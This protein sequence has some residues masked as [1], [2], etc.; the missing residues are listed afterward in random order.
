MSKKINLCFFRNSFRVHDNQFLYNATFGKN[1]HLLPVVCLDPR[2]IDLSKLN[3]KLSTK[4][5]TPVTWNFKMERCNNHRTR[6]IIKSVLALEK[7]L[8]KRKSKLL[9]LFGEPEKLFKDL[10]TF[11]KKHDYNIDQIHTHKEY[12]Y[13]EVSVEKELSKIWDKKIVYHHDTTMVHPDD[14]DFTFEKTPKVFAPFRK[15]IEKMNQP[16]RPLLRMPEELPPFPESALDFFHGKEGSDLLQELYDAFPVEEDKRSAF[17]WPG[18]EAEALERLD[19]YLFKTN[20]AVDYKETRNGMVGTEFS[21]KFSV[22]LAHGCLSPR[23]IWHELDR[24]KKEKKSNGEE[25]DG[26]YW[27]KFELLWRDFFRYVTAGNGNRIFHLHGFRDMSTK[28]EDGTEKA[29]TKYSEKVWKMDKDQ[30]NTWKTGQTGMPFIDACMRELIA[31]GFLNNRGRQNTASFLSKDLEL[32]WRI[33][34]EW[35]EATLKD[36]DVY[37]NYGN[38]QYVSGVGCD[39]REGIRHFN[40]MKQSKD[41]DDDGEYVRLWCPELKDIPDKYVHCPWQMSK[42]DQKKYNCVIGKDYPEPMIV[43]ENWKKYTPTDNNSGNKRITGYF[44]NDN[45]SKKSK[46]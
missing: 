30:F 34:A 22:F 9:V 17:P 35:F 1:I 26:V 24:M 5:K 16:V 36:H 32:D 6:Y 46:Q 38:W 10:D 39:P 29:P 42:E 27:L 2:M 31:T 15:R 21:T 12:A 28:N 14:V 37:S 33:G 7:E 45:S 11:L 40:I 44:K 23:L 41:Y 19:H 8:E 43:V 13:E 25:K 18:G 20:G 4:Y 3:P